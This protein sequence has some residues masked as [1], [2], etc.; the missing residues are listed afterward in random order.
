MKVYEAVAHAVRVEGCEA[1]F[2]LLGD[3]NMGFWQALHSQGGVRIYS[4]RHEA[5]AVAM[6]DGHARATGGVALATVT[7]GPGITQLGTSLL[8][9]SRNRTPL[10]VVVGD[11]PASD[12]NNVQKFDQRHFVQACE[13]EFVPIT[14]AG[15][16]AREM[17]EAFHIART[18]RRPVVVDL[19][20]DVQDQTIDWDFDYRPARDFEP[21]VPAPDVQ[22]LARLADALLAAERPVIIGGW[23]AKVSGAREDLVALADHVG[24]L[25][26]TSLKAKGLFLGHEWDVGLAGAFAAAPAEEALGGADFVLGVG[27]ELGYYTTEGGLLFPEAMVAR[28]DTAPVPTDLGVLPGLYVRGDAA[29]TARALLDVVR[30]RMPSPREGF[31]NAEVRAALAAPIAAREA[32][33]DGMD[34]RQLAAALVEALPADAVVTIG[35]GHF[36]AFPLMYGAIGPEVDL[37]LS[38]QFGAIGQTLPLALGIGAARAGRPHLVMEG[39]GGAMMNLQELETFAREQVPAVVL[40][41]N[42]C[43]FGAEVHKLRAKKFE[44]DLGRWNVSPDF[45]GVARA[46]GGD[47]ERVTDPAAAAVALAR[48]FASGGLFVIDARVSPSVVSDPYLKLQYGV[49]NQAP[50]LRC[51]RAAAGSGA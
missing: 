28:I 50:L 46:L 29:V 49:P 12:L 4:A 39:D 34:P 23:G 38:Y 24:A 10:I 20:G 26:A 13:C 35:A 22:A 3:A 33:S 51:A 37:H 18:R 30:Q 9:A 11:V 17:V 47:G 2:G 1:V 44:P 43:G 21:P 45:V 42:D 15:N 14:G 6:A 32:P 7:S 40:V 16:V 5:G 8:A 31:R 19:P 27:A 48:G 36:W 25:L 41:W